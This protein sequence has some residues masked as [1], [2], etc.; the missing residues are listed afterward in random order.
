MYTVI[1]TGVAGILTCIYIVY[2]SRD[3][4]TSLIDYIFT[5]LIGLMIGLSFGIGIAMI[6]PGKKYIKSASY[7]ISSLQDNGDVSGSFFLGC[8][9][10]NERMKYVFY[11]KDANDYYQM[12]QIDC[13]DV[14]LKYVDTKPR[15]IISKSFSANK[16][17]LPY[18]FMQV[19]YV[20]EIPKG[21]IKNNFTL[22]AQ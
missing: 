17:S 19:N 13:D 9:Y 16:W 7:Q 3:E 2:R 12:M 4:W 20:I 21:T 10:I 18:D 6:I 22:D 15:I 11:Y 1:I 14:L 5:G 8:G